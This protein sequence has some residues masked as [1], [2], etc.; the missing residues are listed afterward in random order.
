MSQQ[1]RKRRR[2]NVSK[3]LEILNSRSLVDSCI[4]HNESVSV[5]NVLKDK[6]KK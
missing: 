2:S 5:Y 4:N 6:N 1:L 3:N